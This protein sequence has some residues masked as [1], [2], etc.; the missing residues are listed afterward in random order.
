MRLTIRVHTSGIPDK[1]LPLGPRDHGNAIW[2]VPVRATKTRWFQSCGNLGS[3]EGVVYDVIDGIVSW[4]PTLAEPTTEA[5]PGKAIHI[6]ATMSARMGL[7][8]WGPNYYYY[9]YYY[10]YDIVK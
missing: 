2:S 6:L 4:Q 7:T 9:Y 1:V 8:D 3:F 10:Y 5:M